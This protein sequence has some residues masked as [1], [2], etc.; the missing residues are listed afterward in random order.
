MNLKEYQEFAARGIHDA[1][2]EREPII[3]F[4][5]GLVGETGE[6]VDDI[7]K[8]VFHGREIPVE[9]TS[10]ELGDVLWYIANIATQYGLSLEDIIQQNVNKLQERYPDKYLKPDNSCL[11]N[12]HVYEGRKV[13]LQ[14]KGPH[15][16]MYNAVDGKFIKF[17]NKEEKKAYGFDLGE[18]LRA[19]Y[20]HKPAV[21]GPEESGQMSDELPWD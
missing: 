14:R 16:A 11:H 2:L 1:T 13:I 10:E 3:G 12:V 19:Q 17:L 7:K 18:N 8:R 9:H 20:G 15:I 21:L 4:A 5:L 6:V